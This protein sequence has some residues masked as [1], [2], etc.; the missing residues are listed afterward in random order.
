MI[1]NI[2][3]SCHRVLPTGRNWLIGTD[4]LTLTCPNK[5]VPTLGTNTPPRRL[6]GN[7]LKLLC[8]TQEECLKAK[9]ADEEK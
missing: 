7:S 4:G 8:E 9:Q 6:S 3:P 5:K 1:H 2:L